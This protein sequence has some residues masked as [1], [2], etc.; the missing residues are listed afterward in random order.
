M[1]SAGSAKGL[2]AGALALLLCA[3]GGCKD[4]D[5]APTECDTAP[6]AMLSGR[7]LGPAGPLRGQVETLFVGDPA[8]YS[9]T[10]RAFA[11]EDGRFSVCL[12][13]G[14]YRLMAIPDGA[15]GSYYAAGG[16]VRSATQADTVTITEQ[17]LEV[18][19][20]WGALRLDMSLPGHADG[21]TIRAGAYLPG[22]SWL[23]RSDAV[24]EVWQERATLEFR[25]LP[26]G[27]YQVSF[28]FAEYQNSAI[29]YWYPHVRERAEAETLLVEIGRERRVEL[30]WPGAVRFSS[31]VHGCWS[32]I[33]P[34]RVPTITAVSDSGMYLARTYTDCD[35]DYTLDFV[36]PEPFRLAVWVGENSAWLGG[37]DFEHAERFDLPAGTH[38][39]DAYVTGG[40]VCKFEVPAPVAGEEIGLRLVDEGSGRVHYRDGVVT[41]AG[42][43]GIPL[44]PAGDY[45]L[46][47]QPRHGCPGWL[48]QWFDRSPDEA[49]ATVIAIQGPEDVVEIA[50][51]M[52]RAGAI[53]G[54]VSRQ[55]GAYL[56]A[57]TLFAFAEADSLRHVVEG[58]AD[59]V[60]GAF[61][62]GGLEDGAY[63][64]WL[65]WGDEERS[66]YPGA[67]WFADAEALVIADGVGVTDLAW[68]VAP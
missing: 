36:L 27:A 12:P 6:L 39:R 3:V 62:L 65:I 54:V 13:P 48:T 26:A 29:P 61:C 15:A 2:L 9:G 47:L 31:A 50:V 19:F 18:D 51:R 40:L 20:R 49:A 25:G 11:G 8:Q 38:T 42:E 4:D 44:L 21:D 5:D 24:V 17:G 46:Q 53:A 59:P 7:L 35:G 64:L 16:C 14:R 23:G 28:Q 32:R 60:T 52:V 34:S 37:V 41:A 58:Q 30:A 57:A 10:E 22:G 67:T 68:E 56:G 63:R 45:T 33:D 55:G 66:W 1:M 43:A